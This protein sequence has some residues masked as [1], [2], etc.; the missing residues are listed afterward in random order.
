MPPGCKA[1]PVKAGSAS[2]F[3][4]LRDC[5]IWGVDSQDYEDIYSERN[6]GFGSCGDSGG[7]DAVG[8]AG[9]E[10]GAITDV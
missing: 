9:V 8:Y 3:K 6:T 2:I 7:D 10:L 4:G 5:S 1:S